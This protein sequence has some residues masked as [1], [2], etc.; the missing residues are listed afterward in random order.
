MTYYDDH[1]ITLGYSS[2]QCTS[3]TALAIAVETL[4][5]DFVI[6]HKAITLREIQLYNGSLVA[7]EL[8]NSLHA[9]S[10]Y[11]GACITEVNC[12]G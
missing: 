4:A 3:K 2:S 12:D 10:L 6:S 8:I 9:M 11:I 5:C 1:T 7:Q